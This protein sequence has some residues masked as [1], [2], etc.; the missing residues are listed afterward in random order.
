MYMDKEVLQLQIFLDRSKIRLDVLRKLSEGEQVAVFL[1]KQMKKHRSSISRALGEL[2]EKG[3]VE[4]ENPEE[5][6]YRTYKITEK[7]RMLLKN[8]K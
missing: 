8:F 7:G 6:S 3:L 1:A 2:R 5:F 4:C